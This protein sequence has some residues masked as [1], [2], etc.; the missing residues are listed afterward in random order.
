MS[1]LTIPRDDNFWINSKKEVIAQLKLLYDNNTLVTI[2]YKNTFCLSNIVEYSHDYIWIDPAYDNN[3]SQLL[4]TTPEIYL[5]SQNQL[6]PIFMELKN[7]K[8]V[9]FEDKMTWQFDLPERVYKLQRRDSFRSYF[10][11]TLSAVANIDDKPDEKLQITDLSLTGLSLL[12]QNFDSN[13][14]DKK[15][16]LNVDIPKFKK[17]EATKMNFEVLV[18]HISILSNDKKK[19]GVQFTTLNRSQEIFLNK[20]QNQLQLHMSLSKK[21]D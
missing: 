1:D 16:I 6:I 5:K 21:G 19:I 2:F 12:G 13:N 7:G 4:I 9:V 18:K 8:E 3:T 15:L 11:I 10:P 14:L 20:W 17:I